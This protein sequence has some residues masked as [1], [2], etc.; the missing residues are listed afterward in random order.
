MPYASLKPFNP[1]G[2]YL[3]RSH[4]EGGVIF[5]AGDPPKKVSDATADALGKVRINDTDPE[6]PHAFHV[7]DELEE[8]VDPDSDP[9]PDPDPDPEAEV[10][11]E[12]EVDPE[13]EAEAD[14]KLDPKPEAEAAGD[15]APPAEA[16][17]A[18]RRRK[19]AAADDIDI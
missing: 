16:K 2:G 10:E 11:A 8:T 5:R 1:R 15:L 3:R 14:P 7:V 4:T 13:T 18:K 19:K 17:R 9:D 6:A 12:V